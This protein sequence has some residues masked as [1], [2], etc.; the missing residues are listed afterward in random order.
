MRKRGSKKVPR[1]LALGPWE[2]WNH[3]QQVGPWEE[4]WVWGTRCAHWDV[5]D[6]TGQVISWEKD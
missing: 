5:R 6:V 2:Q 4:E 1:G 3:L